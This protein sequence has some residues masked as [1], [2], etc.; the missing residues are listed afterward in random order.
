MRGGADGEYLFDPKI[1]RRAYDYGRIVALCVPCGRSTFYAIAGRTGTD[2]IGYAPV[3][4]YRIS[5]EVTPTVD[6]VRLSAIMDI[7]AGGSG[8]KRNA[9][10]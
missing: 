2:I 7:F 1:C 6:S 9:M 5:L 4:Q 10:E 8:L 3:I